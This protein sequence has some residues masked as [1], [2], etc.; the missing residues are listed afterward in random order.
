MHTRR[1]VVVPDIAGDPSFRIWQREA[2]ERGYRSMLAVPFAHGQDVLGVLA[3]YASETGV[4]DG[5]RVKTLEAFATELGYGISALRSRE[6]QREAEAR[7]RKSLRSKD[8]LIA[9]IAHE[10]RTPLTSVIG[11]AEVLLDQG[12]KLSKEELQDLIQVIADE[13]TDLANIVDDLLVAAKAEAGTLHLTLVRVDLRAQ[14][15]QVLERWEPER[16]NHVQF[17]GTPV[18]ASGDPARV[19]QILRNLISNALRYGGDRVGLEVTCQSG[20]GVVRVRDNGSG[21]SPQERETIFQP[22]RRSQAAPGLT[23]SMGL[24]LT[25]SRR[26]ARLMGGDV[27]YRRESDESIF[28]LTLPLNTT[29]GA[30]GNSA[31]PT[32]TAEAPEEPTVVRLSALSGRKPG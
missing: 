14:A 32:E 23:A 2:L 28:E 25:I 13:G 18:H 3:V 7:L 1:P 22:Y 6:F 21:V 19:R 20:W 27:T 30:P 9:T 29:T 26:L 24:G 4:F 31:P 5:A 8:E 11:F 16:I 15:A 12:P 17:D 10:L